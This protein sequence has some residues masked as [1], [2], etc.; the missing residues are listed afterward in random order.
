MLPTTYTPHSIHAGGAADPILFISA[1]G[2]DGTDP[3]PDE[4]VRL[5]RPDERAHYTARYGTAD[6]P[7]VA[8]TGLLIN[9]E[10]W[11]RYWH[12]AGLNWLSGEGE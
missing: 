2:W 12:V 6:N 9:G 11:V 7:V 5:L 1:P 8:V 4:R 10:L 3:V